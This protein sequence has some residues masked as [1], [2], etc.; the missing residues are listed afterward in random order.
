MNISIKKLTKTYG[1]KTSLT[2]LSFQL[3]EHKIYG[4]LG[5]NGAGKTTLMH[6]IAGHILPTTGTVKLNNENPFNNRKL[7]ENICL[8]NETDNFP[9]T[10]KVKEV[11]KTASLFY[12]NWCARTSQSLLKE[13][14]LDETVKVKALS[15]GMVSSLGIIIGLASRA[16]IT[17]FDEPY[18]GLDAAMRARFYEILLEEYEA[19]PRTI[20]LST[21]LIDEVSNLFEEVLILQEGE[22]VLQMTTDELKERSMM[23]HGKSEDVRT[24][25]QGKNV[26]SE[27]E[28]MGQ[29]TAV[30]Y[31]EN[32]NFADAKRLG[33]SVE[34]V[35][36]Q[37]L[38]IHLT[39]NKG[40]V[41]A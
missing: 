30:L 37:D 28:F 27:K 10:L 21:H 17:I 26:L 24:F 11:L 13:F 1:K 12:P 29:L 3:E 33:L 16:A 41:V 9:T 23:I 5:R 4:L 40:G 14:K 34:Q 25:T 31:G 18:I 20:I 39:S 6:I 7:L 35:H 2:D 19:H 36:I 38:M 8:I 15:K 22:L 32:Y